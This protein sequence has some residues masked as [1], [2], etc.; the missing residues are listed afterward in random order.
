[1]ANCLNCGSE[2]QGPFCS[3]CGQRD[4][5]ASP[6]LREM[7]RDAWHEFSG[8]D[9]RFVRTF[10]MLLHPGALTVETL[11]GRRARYVSPLRLYLVASLVYFLMAAAIPNIAAPARTR[12]PG[13]TERIDL[14]RPM[15]PEQRRQAE[16]SL[17]RAPETIRKL[18]QPL[19][20]DPQAVK[21][22]FLGTFPRA[23]FALVPVF[24]GIIAL[25]YWRRPYSQHLVF[26]FHL[27]AALFTIHA[28]AR[29]SHLTGSRTFAGAVG[30]AVFIFA[31]VYL[32]RAFRRVYR[33]PWLGVLVKAPFIAAVYFA[34]V[35][36]AVVAT[37]AWTVL[38]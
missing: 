15:S 13:T 10:R 20:E 22:E 26:A 17:A 35:M 8:W 4:V 11:E 1:M 34:A 37:Y 38:S 33:A 2:L 9:G 29:P 24:A 6:T 14:L 5:P 31:T 21:E 19:L 36:A 27:H 16:Q 23:L 3:E 7:I 18:L 12:M 25:F 32:L 28:V 30:V